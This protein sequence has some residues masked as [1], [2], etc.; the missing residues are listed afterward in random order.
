MNGKYYGCATRRNVGGVLQPRRRAIR[1]S[2]AYRA[3]GAVVESRDERTERT[4][5]ERSDERQA[6]GHRRAKVPHGS[7]PLPLMARRA[8]APSCLVDGYRAGVIYRVRRRALSDEIVTG[9]VR[10]GNW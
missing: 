10:N 6:T 9:D 4:D 1:G 5:T 2:A 7:L 8:S 3:A